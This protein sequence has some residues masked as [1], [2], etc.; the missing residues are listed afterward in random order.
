MHKAGSEIADFGRGLFYGAVEGPYNGAAQLTNHLTSAHLPEL[1]LV[2]ETTL[3]RSVGGVLG[4]VTGVAV[5]VVAAS[6]ATGGIADA[7]GGASGAGLSVGAAALRAGAV[8]AAYSGVFQP[9]DSNSPNFLQDRLKNGAIGFGT[10]AAMGGT[11]SALDG[12]GLFAV[13]EARTLAGSMTYGALSGAA[14]GVVNSEATALLKDGKIAPD[15]KTLATDTASYAAFGMALGAAGYQANKLTAQPPTR[16]TTDQNSAEVTKDASGNI[17]KAVMNMKEVNNPSIPITLTASKMT[18]GSWSTTARSIV[19]SKI[20]APDVTDL[21]INGKTLTVN[22]EN[23]L[24]RQFTDG[25]S[26]TRID[27][28]YSR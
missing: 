24:V 6:I 21:K 20:N 8:G 26:Y 5:D 1:H 10:F 28:Y 14:G 3:D 12:L 25:G 15:L 2:D 18:D 9:T 23:R 11:A 13:P 16:F 27:N 17:V 19:V 22:S 7:V 4:K